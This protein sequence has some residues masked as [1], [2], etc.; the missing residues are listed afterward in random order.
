M[1]VEVIKF[2]SNGVPESIC[3][4][5]CGGYSSNDLLEEKHKNYYF[6]SDCS[7]G[8]RIDSKDVMVKKIFK[9]P[10]IINDCEVK[11]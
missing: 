8:Y 3:C 7:Y 4:W 6:C 5:N 9:Y 1:K 11:I 2:T 10:S